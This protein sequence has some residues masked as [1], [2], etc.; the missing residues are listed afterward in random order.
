MRKAKNEWYYI[1]TL[2]KINNKY[3]IRQIS[4]GKLLRFTT[5]YDPSTIIWNTIQG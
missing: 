1:W 2:S 3:K 5:T 4:A